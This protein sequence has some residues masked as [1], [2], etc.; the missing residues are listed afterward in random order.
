MLRY[1][2]IVVNDKKV[3]IVSGYKK[4]GTLIVDFAK[5]YEINKEAKSS[6]EELKRIINL[7]NIEKE[8]T[9]ICIK[10][11]VWTKWELMPTLSYSEVQNLLKY[12]KEDILDWNSDE[13]YIQFIRR[14]DSSYASGCK[15]MEIYFVAVPKSIVK[16]AGKALVQVNMK[17]DV[18]TYWLGEIMRLYEEVD[19]Y[20]SVF[21]EKESAKIV[22]WNDEMIVKLAECDA[23]PISV[24]NILEGWK[25]DKKFNFVGIDI[26][27]SEESSYSQEDIANYLA[28][29]ESMG[30]LIRREIAYDGMMPLPQNNLEWQMALGGLWR[31][32]DHN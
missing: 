20:V 17:I 25:K 7:S 6:V 16:F 8:K 2:S 31:G 22:Y 29:I 27:K 11:K 21:L 26:F 19:P 14:K 15:D 3:Y 23:N 9:C 10:S 12:Q 18:I 5:D 24:S 1:N 30:G 28:I 13:T 4:Q 32:L